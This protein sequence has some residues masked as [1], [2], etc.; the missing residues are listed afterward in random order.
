[1]I[2]DHCAVLIADAYQ[3]GLLNSS[4][5]TA[6]TAYEIIRRNAMEVI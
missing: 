4:D 6:K 2:G 3:K 1:M 5:E